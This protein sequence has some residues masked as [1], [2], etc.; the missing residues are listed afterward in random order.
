MADPVPVTPA[1]GPVVVTLPAE[2]DMANSGQVRRELYAALATGVAVVVA[3]MTA[4]TFC[5]T[6]G[7]RALVMAHAV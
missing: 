3:G 5:D 7:F 2:I 1:A 4:T 6:M